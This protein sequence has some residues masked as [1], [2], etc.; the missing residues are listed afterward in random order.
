MIT[1]EVDY[2]GRILCWHLSVAFRCPAFGSVSVYRIVIGAF[3]RIQGEAG[4]AI[5][6]CFPDKRKRAYDNDNER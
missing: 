4:V 5:V 2:C 1:F 3:D 6:N